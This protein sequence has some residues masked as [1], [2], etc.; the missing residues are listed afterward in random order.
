MYMLARGR[1]FLER[2][3]VDKLGTILGQDHDV[4]PRSQV[5]LQVISRNVEAESQVL[6]GD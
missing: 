4:S 5:R 6:S 1:Q 2:M 3:S